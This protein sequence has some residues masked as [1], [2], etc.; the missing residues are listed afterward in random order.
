MLIGEGLRED[1][2]RERYGVP[3]AVHV[4]ATLALQREYQMRGYQPLTREELGHQALRDIII[5]QG[6]RPLV[7]ARGHISL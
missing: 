5:L 6:R 3:V 7:V 1:I 2:C 4:A